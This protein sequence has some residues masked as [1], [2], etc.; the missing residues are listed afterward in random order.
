M[1]LEDKVP[2]AFC[3]KVI[4]RGAGARASKLFKIGF[5]GDYFQGYL[6]EGA[7]ACKRGLEA[8]TQLQIVGSGPTVPCPARNP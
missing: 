2:A 8:E 4:T 5:L 6:V 1:T 7:G 3:A